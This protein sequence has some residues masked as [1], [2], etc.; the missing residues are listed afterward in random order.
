[1][2]PKC[3][4]PEELRAD[5]L[6]QFHGCLSL[7][8]EKKIRGMFPQYLFFRNEY[9]DD[10]WNV[11]S[12]P[13]RICTCTSCG[14]SFEAVRG[15]YAKGRL[16]HEKCN[17]PECGERVEGIA[18]SKYKYDMPSLER[19]IKVAVARPGKDGALLI[20]AGDARRVF[21]HDNLVGEIDW[22]PTKRYIF[23]RHG[24]CEWAEK[25]IR[26]GCGPY[27][28]KELK[29]IETK[30]ISDPFQPNCMGWNDYDGQYRV[31][32]LGDALPQTDLKYSQILEYFE[33][34]TYADIDGG[35]A[36]RYI[37]KYLGWYCIHPQIEMAV[38]FGLEGAVEDLIS[39][40]KK[41]VKL[42][43]WNARRP[44][45]FM[46]ISRQEMR[47]FQKEELDF[48][49][50]KNWKEQG[51][52][53]ALGNYLD[54]CN[55]IGGKNNM[56]MLRKCAEESGAT[57]P[58][59]AKYVSSLQPVCARYAVDPK[60]ILQEWKD[61]LD[62]AK[63]LGYDLTEKTVAMPKNLT[64]R[65]DAAAETIKVNA[66]Q[67]EMKK[68]KKRRRQLETQYEFRL[69]NYCILVPVSTDEIVHE[70]KTLQHC[71]GGYAP[72]HIEGKTTILFLR[73]AKRPGR[74]FLTI[75]LTTDHGKTSI[76][77]IHGYRNERYDGAVDPGI[78][79]GWFL[80]TWLRWVNEGSE[81][82][83]EGRPILPEQTEERKS[84][85]KTA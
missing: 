75:E 38:K 7:E 59:A 81:R 18:A 43:N 66:H 36:A 26:W 73:K 67:E 27:S 33:E 19:W 3:T 79:F 46:R 30:T 61:Y 82:D 21:S 76:K 47:L 64:E 65:H 28:E 57:L 17:C 62:L 77:Q 78:R 45:Q 55:E 63:R 37:V 34:R 53:L 48:A 20:E 11:S 2:N 39:E 71:V 58:A 32:G 35:A 24:S 10:G 42:L 56:P 14:Q 12:D 52:S 80:E 50:L 5:V 60:R 29:W 6:T 13:V 69:G 74:P 25:V 9:R 83:R 68:Y 4:L 49:D 31:I 1:M 41:N 51:G 22:Y 85:V 40:G 72:R 8:E 16:H 23:S 54:I 44:E 70:G 84:E 15:N